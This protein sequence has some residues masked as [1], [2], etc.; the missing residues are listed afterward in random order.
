[1]NTAEIRHPRR[2]NN[3]LSMCDIRPLTQRKK[4]QTPSFDNYSSRD[5]RGAVTLSTETPILCCAVTVT[6][7]SGSAT[8]TESNWNIQWEAAPPEFTHWSSCMYNHIMVL[9]VSVV[10]FN[11]IHNCVI[12][13]V[14]CQ[15][16]MYNE[17][18]LR[19]QIVQK[20]HLKK[21]K[22]FQY[23]KSYHAH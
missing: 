8:V 3:R 11:D 14:K 15:H 7:P 19:G 9:Y 20:L 22:S 16:T 2:K 4:K 5:G 13:F 18:R 17:M 23:Y 10:F 21:K 12:V 1:M 6:A